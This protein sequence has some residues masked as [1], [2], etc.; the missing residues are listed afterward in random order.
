[1]KVRDAPHPHPPGSHAQR[2]DDRYQ[3]TDDR[4]DNHPPGCLLLLR[5][6]LF[7]LCEQLSI[8]GE[9]RMRV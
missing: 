2:R 8:S 3:Q 5:F 1:M 6:S 7:R 9:Q 4:P